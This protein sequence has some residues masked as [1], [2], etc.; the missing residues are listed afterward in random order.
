MP[1]LRVVSTRNP[2]TAVPVHT[3]GHQTIFPGEKNHLFCWKALVKKY[4]QLT[5]FLLSTL[6]ISHGIAG[7]QRRRGTRS[8]AGAGAE[9]KRTDFLKVVAL[10]S[11]ERSMWFAEVYMGRRGTCD[12]LT[13]AKSFIDC[14]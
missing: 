6:L 1:P 9:D 13:V 3:I 14:A 4:K 7:T 10:P 11:V 2:F 8:A 12:F 5:A